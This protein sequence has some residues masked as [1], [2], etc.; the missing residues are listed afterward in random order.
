MIDELIHYCIQEIGLDGEAGAQID[1]LADYI[2]AFHD[3]HSSRSQLPNQMVDASYQ[4]FVFRQL[5]SHP[6]V[7]VGLFVPGV[8]FKSG[9]KSGI[10]RKFSGIDSPTPAKSESQAAAAPPEFDW[11][12]LLPYQSL[13]DQDGL[14]Q[15][16]QIHGDRLRLVLRNVVIKQLLV[17]AEDVFLPPSAYRTLQLICRSREIPVLSTDIGSALHLDQKTVFYICKRLIDLG[18]VIKIRARETG[19]VAS[20]FLAKRFED[21]CEILIQQRNA[22]N[23]DDLGQSGI[24]VTADDPTASTSK[25][26]AT[27]EASGF[28]TDEDAEGED[29]DQDASAPTVTVKEEDPQNAMLHDCEHQDGSE[30]QHAAQ[31]GLPVFEYLEPDMALL[32]INS[33]PEL[34]RFRIYLVCD[35][36]SSK[37]TARLGLLN[38]IN[39][40]SAKPQRRSFHNFLEHAIVHGFLQ[41][42]NILVA[43][44]GRTHKG[45]RMTPKGYEEMQ[46]M[47][48]GDFSDAAT[49]Q[50]Q[51][52]ANRL[53]LK[54]S[55]DL[56]R[57]DSNLPR[58]LTLERH[59]YEEVTRAGP[60]GRTTAQLMAQLHGN[61]HFV[62]MIDQLLMRAEDADGEPSMSDM[63]IRGFHEHK[64]RLR[65]TKIYSQHAWVLQC[66]NEGYL[67][68]NDLDLLASAGGPSCFH[69]MSTAWTAPEQVSEGL[70]SLSKDL[71]TPTP[72][73]G[74]ARIGR[75]PKKRP[76]DDDPDAPPP[77]RGR[78][79]KPIDP[80]APTPKRGRP[81]KQPVEADPAEAVT[82][83][84]R[85][86]PRKQPIEATE[87][88]PADAAA[89]EAASAVSSALSS[90][91]PSEVHSADTLARGSTPRTRRRQALETSIDDDEA[92]AVPDSPAVSA[93]SRRSRRLVKDHAPAR[94]TSLLASSPILPDPDNVQAE[95]TSTHEA[96][97]ASLPVA[98][99]PVAPVPVEP[100]PVASPLAT[101]VPTEQESAV[102]NT[103]A[104]GQSAKSTTDPVKASTDL[105]RVEDLL[106]VSTDAKGDTNSA[107]PATPHA[108]KLRKSR[109]RQ[110]TSERKART[111]LTQLRSSNALVQCIRE[112]GGAMDTLLIPTQ[113]S[114]FVE[115]HGFA[116]DAQLM[117][118]RDRKVREKALTSAVN[119]GLL[120]RT[121]IRLD[122]PSA[123]FPRR[124]IVYLAD[125]APEQLQAYC[126]A[127]KDGREGWVD[128][129]IA[130]TAL[131]TVTDSVAVDFDDATR[132]T[133]PWHMQDSLRLSELPEGQAQLAALR[134][135]F[136]DV[137]SVYR[138]HFGFLGGE[139][140]RLKAFHYACAKFISLL[141]SS[142]N[143]GTAK[144][145]LPLS[146]FWTEAPLELYLAFV[147]TP[148]VLESME[149]L[150]LDPKIRSLPVHALPNNVKVVLG[151][152]SGVPNDAFVALYSLATQLSDLSVCQLDA[153]AQETSNDGLPSHATIVVLPDRVPLYDWGHE[154]QEKPLTEVM[155]IGLYSDKINLYWVK[156]QVSCFRLRKPSDEIGGGAQRSAA[157]ALDTNSLDNVNLFKTVPDGL[158]IALYAGKAWRPYHQLRPSQVKFL[159]RI[160]IQD[161]PSATQHDI[162]RLAYI[163]LA[164]HQVVR[165]VMQAKL[166]RANKPFDPEAP[167][168]RDK[169]PHFSWPLKLTTIS[170]P[171][172]SYRSLPAAPAAKPKPTPAER[173]RQGRMT[174]LTKARQLRERRD[175][176]FQMMLDQAF[177]NAQGADTLR[178]KIET[179]LAIVRRKFVA[180]DVRFDAEAVR[181]VIMRAIRSASGIKAMP[182]VRAEGRRKRRLNSVA[183][184]EHQESE[185]R[186][187]DQEDEVDEHEDEDEN[188]AGVE[189]GRTK[190]DRRVRRNFD[191]I[192]FWTP[193]KKE[194]LRDAAVILR[195]RDQVRGRS[196]WSALLQVVDEEERV[197]TKGV[198]M[199]QWRSQYYRMRSLYGEESYLAALESRWIPVYLAAREEGTLHDP[200][201][202]AATGFDLV[203]QIEL[204]RA[205]IDKNAVQRSL[206][207]PVAC[208]H[209][210][211]EL[212]SSNDFTGSWKDEFAEEPAERRFEP[213]Y[214]NTELGLT[215]KRFETLL[216]AAFGAEGATGGGKGDGDVADLVAEWAVRIVIAS[217]SSDAENRDAS[218]VPIAEASATSLGVRQAVPTPVDEATKSEFCRAVG[219]TR[220]EE[221][222]Q[223]MLD[224]KLIRS[225]T[226]DP[227]NRRKPGTN[228]V[229]TEEL[230]K[231]FPDSTA[232]SRLAGLD[233]QATLTHRRSAF[234]EVCDDATDGSLVEPIQAD[235]E[236]A[237]TI[238]LMQLEIMDAEI[239]VRPFETLRQ[240]PAFNARVLNDEDL[241]TLISIKGKSGAMEVLNGA[242]LPLPAIPQDDALEWVGTA[243][244]AGVEA[245]D[246]REKWLERFEAMLSSNSALDVA[247]VERLRDFGKCLFDAGPPGLLLN[248]DTDLTMAEVQSLTSAPLP[249]AF[250][251]PLT[252]D[253]TLIAS[254]H[255]QPY[256]LS[257]PSRTGPQLPH[258]Y[259]TLSHPST[260]LWRQLLETVIALTFQRPGLNLG[261][262]ASRFSTVVDTASGGRKKVT[263]TSFA[264]VW[265]A[266]RC[267][268]DLGVVEIRT[269]GGGV[270]RWT[271]HAESKR[272]IWA[273]FK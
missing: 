76:N 97:V 164:P 146:F 190:R 58:E 122:R 39:V 74:G 28:D 151:L 92:S 107:L 56:A 42:V 220:I 135:P 100:P 229:F 23:V 71:F 66:A 158:D 227:M 8:P 239:D 143:A 167:V 201:F 251:S 131:M 124:Q 170:L 2:R 182:A 204:L 216:G 257:L 260:S 160:D 253:P 94:P 250:F 183:A 45:L 27:A 72:R 12:D 87:A 225:L 195:V 61:G 116:S 19:T 256:S 99:L 230:Q 26:S 98:S 117:D 214:P 4:A 236:A 86:R 35:A 70:A 177:G 153:T 108:S 31:S 141:Q 208:H 17:G 161:I 7:G 110:S 165:A 169:K 16:Q 264:D 83:R 80:D 166:D 73:K 272:K 114:A 269:D 228:F 144:A 68:Q 125:L 152:S 200:D 202:P 44:A 57:I 241:E 127:V 22:G 188:T 137:I 6:N 85:G 219:D 93:A 268:V 194:L 252:S 162:D 192:N 53:N 215:T 267:L 237:A 78:P 3:D 46:E 240:N 176:Q 191:H 271:L 149:G 102:Q 30:A 88:S 206:V 104:T 9:A 209:L 82:P 64:Q 91:A 247:A 232:A 14:F 123:A 147:P 15:L 67:D 51:A 126:E 113:L 168:K 129:K 156:M 178:P 65:T 111:N 43:S 205:K 139:M 181:R 248:D 233:L 221:A 258:I 261:W 243:A 259:T 198:I 59:V 119:N 263:G 196:D 50:A 10:N 246:L 75:P 180:G 244:E 213:F 5:V 41:V 171:T 185:Q 245:G 138:Q 199:A 128:G 24:E 212:E 265:S 101:P 140:L 90:P 173:E 33:R 52:K 13:A 32:W 11:V 266:V 96:P 145:G 103:A 105:S 21:R 222:M 47:L 38:R 84:K 36:T 40:A 48:R 132:F 254:T 224:A 226:F 118:L 157:A 207:K 262:L 203:A 189:S 95:Q 34:L 106:A 235:G 60:S 175:E 217:E 179:A 150:L 120:R 159:W 197:K 25:A 154:D 79:R 115:K 134:Q 187:E 62:R 37:V 109:A 136:R 142:S 77:K 18:L 273:G 223:R 218:A 238:L 174:T 186:D 133:K 49:V 63:L 148:P 163:T 130:K 249:L 29:A 184:K 172:Q 270:G 81:R 155:D 1:R 69:R 121:Y 210:P 89:H 54:L 231:L 211:L 20:Y 255:I 234:E 193:A 55:Q 242:V 112:A